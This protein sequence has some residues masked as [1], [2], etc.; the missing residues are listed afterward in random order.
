MEVIR[1]HDFKQLRRQNLSCASSL[2]ASHASVLTD[3][4]S[5]ENKQFRY[6][7]RWIF[8]KGSAFISY[9][10]LSSDR[11]DWHKYSRLSIAKSFGWTHKTEKALSRHSWPSK[12]VPSRLTFSSGSKVDPGYT[13]HH[14]E[15]FKGKTINGREYL[16]FGGRS[17]GIDWWVGSPA[18][19]RRPDREALPSFKVRAPRATLLNPVKAKMYVSARQGAA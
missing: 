14:F 1:N 2:K 3:I 8:L 6:I 16:A 18:D 15:K 7:P 11:L 12:G 17:N 5:S 4:P 19:R 10:T 13:R 9:H